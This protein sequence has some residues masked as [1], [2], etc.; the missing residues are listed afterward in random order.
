MH[1]K[2]TLASDNS[3]TVWAVKLGHVLRVFLQ[4][5]HLH[6]ATL[7][8]ASMADVALVWLLTRVCSHVSLQL[9]CVSAG[10]TA[11]TALEGSLPSMRAD[12]S[13]QFTHLHTTIVTHRAFEGLL[14]CMF[15]AAMTH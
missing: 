12:V 4:N 15:V 9:V 2:V 14:M 1:T 3:V 6:G 13:F 8:E 7:C 5:M 11:K 10:I